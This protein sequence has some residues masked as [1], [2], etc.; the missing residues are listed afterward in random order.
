MVPNM[1]SGALEKGTSDLTASALLEEAATRRVER[2]LD[3]EFLWSESALPRVTHCRRLRVSSEVG[4]SVVAAES[5]AHYANLQTCGSVWACPVDSAKIRFQRAGEVITI[6]SG[7]LAQGGGALFS[8]MTA[9]HNQTESLSH[10]L[11][12]T[13]DAW[14][15]MQGSRPWKR[16]VAEFHLDGMIRAAEV[17]RS[18]ANGWHAHLHVAVLTSERLE[19]LEILRFESA[20]Y[21][22]WCR[23]ILRQGRGKPSRRHGVDVRP[24]TDG[25][26]LGA[27]LTKVEGVAKELTRADRKR[28]R[29]ESRTPAQ[30]L[31]DARLFG[32]RA[33]RELYREYERATKGRRM[34]TMSRGLKE[35]YNVG[36]KTDEEIAEAQVGGEK[37]MEIEGVLWSQLVR[38]RG[39]TSAVL[40]AAG[41]NGAE[42]AW[43]LIHAITKGES[44]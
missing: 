24:I 41:E 2:F 39:A 11:S 28:G 4:V 10:C 37:I 40:R 6:L 32:D 25:D 31:S 1:L 8:T 22:L 42:A 18:D 20:L 3:L 35:R 16:L 17:T 26:G 9:P 36:E 14:K 23:A 5:I 13:A 43:E 12:D 34:L 7:H 38:T 29:H 27:Y 44:E 19:P 15:K 33:D 30:I 21:E